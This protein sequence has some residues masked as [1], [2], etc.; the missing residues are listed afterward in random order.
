M[1]MTGSRR[2]E[3]GNKYDA[4]GVEDLFSTITREEEVR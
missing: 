1:S 2:E 3:E 4:R